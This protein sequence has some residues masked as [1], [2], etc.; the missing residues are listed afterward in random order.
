MRTSLF[1]IQRLAS[2]LI[3][4]TLSV[5]ILVVGKNI[6]VPLAF[7]T[8]FSFML[9]PICRFIERKVSYRLPAI[10]L[11]FLVITVPILAIMLLFSWLF[12]DVYQDLPSI[13]GKLQDGFGTAFNWLNSQF[14]FTRL[15]G[16]EWMQA[17]SKSLLE[18][19][20]SY[21]GSGVTSSSAFFVNT[22]LVFIYTFLLLLYRS[23]FK[24]FFLMQVSDDSESNAQQ[25]LRSIQRLIQQYLYGLLIVMF[26]LGILNSLGLWIIGISY[27]VFWG[28][29]A[30]FLAIIP[31]IGTFL[32][33][34]MTVVYALATTATIWQPA[35]VIGLFTVVQFLEGN[36]ITPK[37]V[38]E[39]VKVNPL[40][41]I[42]SLVIGG[43]LWGVAGLILAVPI[44]ATLK[45][46]MEQVDFMKPFSL[47]L[48]SD[49][50]QK[51]ELFEQRFNEE[52]FRLGHLF[53]KK[54]A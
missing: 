49:L 46:I 25:L 34:L 21:L 17:N 28:F 33:G 16:E 3:V 54:K 18:G 12:V 10:G 29:L 2:F 19:P 48:S 9:L 41:I 37:I 53:K 24:K 1:D 42:L 38:G 22:G 27:P 50:Y 7:A 32:G 45:R 6:L 40:A 11:S 36:I 4:M 5:Y 14:R 15:S 8:L 51:D 20:L 43:S 26:L 52:R 35:A 31:F 23:A 13:W 39:S 30:A 47:L 44:I